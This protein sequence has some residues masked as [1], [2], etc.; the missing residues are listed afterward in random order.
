MSDAESGV[1]SESGIPSAGDLHRYVCQLGGKK[2]FVGIRVRLA[3]TPRAPWKPSAIIR[4]VNCSASPKQ[5][6]HPPAAL[7][8]AAHTQARWPGCARASCAIPDGSTR[9]VF[10]PLATIERLA[11]LVP[12]PRPHQLTYPGVL[13]PPQAWCSGI[14][15]ASHSRLRSPSR[16]VIQF[17]LHRHGFAESTKRNWIDTARRDAVATP[18]VP[19]AT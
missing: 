10:E 18:L 1:H 4:H 11:A 12:P 13:L 7:E 9:L 2:L 19:V 17:P 16:G 3:C 5:L 15:P 14:V 8:L 6:N